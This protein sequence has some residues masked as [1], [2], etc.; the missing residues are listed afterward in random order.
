MEVSGAMQ[1]WTMFAGPNVFPATYEVQVIDR[2]APSDAWQTLYRAR[3]R[4]YR[5]RE[6]FYD[7]ERLRSMLSRYSWP[8][9]FWGPPQA[10]AWAAREVF[11]ER[12]EAVMV[13]CRFF[14]QQTPTAR[15]AAAGVRYPGHYEAENVV[16]RPP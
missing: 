15:E 16:R 13:R 12:P 14:R 2:G 3:S 5:W 7:Q 1:P 10:C 8:F 9:F 4:E 11:R 6:S